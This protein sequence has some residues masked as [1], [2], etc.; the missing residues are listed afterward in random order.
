MTT[1]AAPSVLVGVAVG[2]LANDDDASVGP[3]LLVSTR[4]KGISQWVSFAH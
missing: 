4:V 3:L 2:P 1:E